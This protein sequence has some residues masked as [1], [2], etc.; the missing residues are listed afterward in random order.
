MIFGIIR[1]TSKFVIFIPRFLAQVLMT[2]CKT[3]WKTMG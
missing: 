3:G 1:N 2:F